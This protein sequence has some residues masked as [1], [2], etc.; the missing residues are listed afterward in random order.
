MELSLGGW[1]GALLGTIV[2]VVGYAMIIPGIERRMRALDKS[3][4]PEEREAFE[5]KLSVMRR[6]V[7]GADI[8]ALASLG[9]WF[10]RGVV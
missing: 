1:L 8:L 7:L 10:G 5:E 3:V 4:T 9:Y 6:T 2:A